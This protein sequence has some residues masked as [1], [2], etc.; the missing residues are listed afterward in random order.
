MTRCAACKT[1][2]FF[3]GRG[4]NG[5]KVCSAKCESSLLQMSVKDGATNDPGTP[6][7]GKPLWLA[8]WI[9]LAALAT[10][11][12]FVIDLAGMNDGSVPSNAV[13]VALGYALGPMLLSTLI[14]FWKKHR[15]FH[16]YFRFAAIISWL[17]VLSG[18]GQLGHAPG[19]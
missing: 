16:A 14:L 2:I 12:N 5:H 3:G 7:R 19:M 8:F 18:L 10:T 15:S 4:I 1:P 9:L 13:S 11:V 17:L 6:K